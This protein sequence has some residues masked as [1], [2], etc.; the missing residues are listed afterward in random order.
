MIGGGSTYTPELVD[1]LV[2][3]RDRLPISEIHLVDLD[4]DRLAV[5]GPLTQR[6]CARAGAGDVVVRWGSDRVEGVRDAAFV[7]SQIRVGGMEAR[8]RDEL[9]GREF[10]LIGQETV[11]V[12][13]FA[14]ALRTI[15]VALAIARDIEAHAPGAILLNFTNPSGLVTEALCRHSTVNTIGLCNVPWSFITHFARGLHVERH[16]LELDY[17]GLNHLSWVRS[18]RVHGEERIGELL[19]GMAAMAE[20]HPPAPDGEPGWTAE[21]IRMLAAMPNYYLLYYYE[22]AAFLRHQAAHPT[23]ASEVMAIEEQLM[24]RYRDPALDEKPPELELRGG[25]FY[26]ETA[27]ALMADIWSDAGTTHI[28]NVVNGGA[29]PNLADD[30]V[31]E[32]AAH[33]TRAGATA[34]PTAPLRPDVDALVHTM[35]SF[36]LLT[37]QA[38]VE[39][40]EEAALRALITNP[41]GPQA[42]DAPALWRRLQ[43]V[44]APHLAKLAPPGEAGARKR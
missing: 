24:E 31:V 43:A 2:R 28:V 4:A 9:L 44:N 32:T 39:G 7:V 11:G 42:H 34:I 1:G 29:I 38:A 16:E 25:A 21:S 10:G 13:G 40:S 26:S 20:R 33:V 18:A 14:N 6:M 23:R 35:K 27:A 3:R 22:T 30:V 37:V 8:E 19:D 15:P 36:E 17:V 5:L 41:L 12:G